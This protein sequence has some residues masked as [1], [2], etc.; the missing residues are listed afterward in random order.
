LPN[1]YILRLIETYRVISVFLTLSIYIIKGLLSQYDL[2]FML[3]LACCI[4]ASA[5]L[6]MYLYRL[7]LDNRWRLHILLVL[8]ITAISFL[9]VLTG[10]CDSPF[11]WYFLNPLLVI[12]C[13]MQAEEKIFYLTV[14][15][16]LFVVIGYLHETDMGL[17]EY[18]LYHL[19]VVLSYILII[20]L[21]NILVNSFKLTIKKQEELQEA[22]NNL[23][24][25]NA[26]IREL[27][28]DILLMYE[29][30]Q[31]VTTQKEKREVLNILL[32]FVGRIVPRAQ[33]F[34]FLKD[35]PEEDCFVSL[36]ALDEDVKQELIGILK[37]DFP[38]VAQDEIPRLTL[39]TGNQV[40]LLRVFNYKDYGVIG[41]I[42]SSSDSHFVDLEKE[43]VALRL[44][45]FSRLGALLLEK[46]E[47]EEVNYELIIADEQNRLADDIHD[48]V[49]QRLFALSCMLYNTLRNWHRFSDAEKK[50]NVTLSRETV[51]SSLQDLRSTIYNLSPKKRQ[52]DL[53]KESIKSYL[54]DLEKLSGTKIDIRIN[55]PDENLS[56]GAKKALYRIIIEST[57][58]AIRHGKCQNVWIHLNIGEEE[59]HLT[60]SDDGRGF[61]L[62]Q[63][64]DTRSG[65]GL[66]NIKSLIRMY[67]GRI[68]ITSNQGQGTRYEIVF[69]N[70]DI[71]NKLDVN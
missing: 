13:Y 53:F 59:T 63:T 27:V 28:N 36:T 30:V 46:I 64:K 40:F 33:V 44:S 54:G 10:G 61:D 38:P 55:G 32:D 71:L 7:N 66:Y 57:G 23:Q 18:L 29:A 15:V 58:N 3:F 62:A 22:N 45:F 19:N 11:I 31:S 47:I 1:N 60:I 21:V 4:I 68:K 52:Y 51:E 25:S 69:A 37:N 12:S 24:D 39:Q 48:S 43:E 41:L 26:K 2:F 9:I 56:T 20:I 49:I 16:L 35:C 8:E 67:G 65:L 14:N 34:F 70:R 5:F 17:I 50:E 6:F 42:V